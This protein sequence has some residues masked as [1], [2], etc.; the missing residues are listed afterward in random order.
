MTKTSLTRP[1]CTLFVLLSVPPHIPLLAFLSRTLFS[2][3]ILPH[4]QD[5][6]KC[7][8]FLSLLLLTPSEFPFYTLLQ[9]ALLQSLLFLVTPLYG[10]SSAAPVPP[11]Y[12]APFLRCRDTRSFLYTPFFFLMCIQTTRSP[13]YCFYTG[14]FFSH[15][16]FLPELHRNSASHCQIAARLPFKL[17]SS[18]YWY[19]HTR[20]TD[21]LLL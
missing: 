6:C 16:T 13:F 11:P 19:Q 21:A 18:L 4:T 17:H 8:A 9:S 10:S 5:S 1:L 12:H 3:S 7:S 15:P 20:T 14:C 2:S